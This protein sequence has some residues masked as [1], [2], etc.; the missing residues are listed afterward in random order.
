MLDDI[1]LLEFMGIPRSALLKVPWE[2]KESPS[3]IFTLPEGS[4][5]LKGM[6]DAFWLPAAHR[7]RGWAGC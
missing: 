5:R 4:K 6:A 2:M 1:E 7:W 3:E